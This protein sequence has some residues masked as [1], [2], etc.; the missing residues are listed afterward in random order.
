MFDLEVLGCAYFAA[1]FLLP[2]SDPLTLDESK[3]ICDR[4]TLAELR[5]FRKFAWAFGGKAIS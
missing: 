3:F 1:V 4:R 5:L 2:D